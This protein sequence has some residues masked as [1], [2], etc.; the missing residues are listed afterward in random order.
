MC[1]TH[2]FLPPYYNVPL[3]SQPLSCQYIILLNEFKFECV[4]ELD[5][6]YLGD[7]VVEFINGLLTR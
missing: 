7:Y 1:M 4:I 5:V 6:L 3:P 2:T